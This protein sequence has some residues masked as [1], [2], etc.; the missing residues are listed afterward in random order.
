MVLDMILLAWMA[1]GYKYVDYTTGDGVTRDV[2]DNENL[3]ISM[4]KKKFPN[5]Q[6][7]EITK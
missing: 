7:D 5:E 3:D 2:D 1:T 4:N 6:D